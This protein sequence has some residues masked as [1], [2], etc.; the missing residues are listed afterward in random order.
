MLLNINSCLCT[1]SLSIDSFVDTSSTS[2]NSTQDNHSSGGYVTTSTKVKVL[3]IKPLAS[4]LHPKLRMNAKEYTQYKELMDSMKGSNKHVHFDCFSSRNESASHI[5]ALDD[6]D[7]D[8]VPF[9]EFEQWR[10][11]RLKDQVS[12]SSSDSDAISAKQSERSAFSVAQVISANYDIPR[13]QSI[14]ANYDIPRKQA[15]STNYD[16]P[17]KQAISTNYDI[18][19]KK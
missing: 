7:T 15:I 10:L 4:C 17:R 19:I 2:K 8:F 12:I 11:Q 6:D 18:P 16:I 5:N 9:E 14:S 3:E 1:S 13:K